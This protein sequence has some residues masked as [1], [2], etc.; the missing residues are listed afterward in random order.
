MAVNLRL[1]EFEKGILEEIATLSGHS[2]ATVRDIL[3]S[4][5]LRQLEYVMNGEPVAVPYLGTIKV[6]YKGDNYVSGTR[7]ADVEC[8]F[9]TSELFKRLVGDIQDGESDLISQLLQKKIK[10]ALQEILDKAD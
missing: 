3:E 7:V 1:D 5:F 2:F 6:I 4:A 10:S 8:H 9:E